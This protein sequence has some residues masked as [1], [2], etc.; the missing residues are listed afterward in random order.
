MKIEAVKNLDDGCFYKIT[1]P[2][3]ASEFDIKVE[4]TEKI[5]GF[6]CSYREEPFF[7]SAKMGKCVKEIPF[8]TQ[9][10][11]VK[12][13]DG[14][15]SV[16]F[17]MAFEKFRTSFYGKDDGLYI[18]A[19]TGDTNVVGNSFYAYYKVSGD[20]FYKLV[21]VAAKAVSDKFKTVSL[22][23]DKKKPEF[24]KYFGWC[25]WDSFYEKVKAEDVEKG[26]ENFKKGGIIP[27]L[28]ILDD[29]WQT[30]NSEFEGR[31]EWKLTEFYANEKFNHGLSETIKKAKEEFGVE[32]F[33]VWHAVMGYWGGVETTAPKMQKYFPRLSEA[34]H[35]IGIKLLNPVRWKCENFPFGIIDKERAFD[36]YND[37][38][39]Y[40]KNEGIDG[41]KIDVQAS[42]EA[43][44]EN[45]G[46]RIEM[47]EKVRGG[48][49][50][51]VCEN[52]DHEMINC[53][54]CSNDI[55]YHTKYTNMMR[56]SNDF[57]PDIP[58]S[59]PKHIFTNA[60]NSIWMS[61]FT[62]CD[63]DMFQTKHEYALYH[64]SARAIS[65]GPVYVS[66]RVDEHD[67]EL[68][69]ALSTDDGEILLTQSTALPTEDCLFDISEDKPYKIFSMNKYNGVVGVFAMSREE[70]ETSVSAKDING[71][72]ADKYIAYSRKENKTFV[73]SDKNKINVSLKECECDIIT[74]AEIREGFAVIGITDKINCGGAIDMVKKTEDGY[75]IHV[76]TSGNLKMYSEQDVEV[77]VNGSVAKCNQK[78]NVYDI[79][80]EKSY[81]VITVK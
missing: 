43:H 21:E 53:M 9:W 20:D 1:A 75:E 28:L 23:C 14:S 50:K 66:D 70:K 60:V 34:I 61:Q 39:T 2:E 12:H 44:G 19:I 65:G 29:G 7:M 41:V 48:L 54:S 51:S 68:I 33:F 27:K 55:I 3:K 56:S 71:L 13:L 63:W 72:K 80:I 46:G 30:V 31:G 74:I 18:S 69:K 57:F 8:E 62:I 81:S 47:V 59:H 32:K 24:M 42:V 38:H 17:S 49:E 77:F 52:F 67:F 5:T 15:Y 76:K 25:T 78:D 36:F 73:L 26:L 4:E 45:N 22:K 16:Y 79:L 64:A 40:L 6:C 37:Y 58:E 11:G 10:L 35:P